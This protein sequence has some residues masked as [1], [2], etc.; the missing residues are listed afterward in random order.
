[1]HK[2]EKANSIRDSRYI[3]ELV[4]FALRVGQY[5]GKKVEGA[6]DYVGNGVNKVKDVVGLGDEQHPIAHAAQ[7]AVKNIASTM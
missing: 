7:T 2:A 3:A 4:L 6:T 1:M 5:L